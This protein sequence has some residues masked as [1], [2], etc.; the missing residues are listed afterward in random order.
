MKKSG[1]IL[2][3]A[4]SA[5]IVFAYFST[6]E[7]KDDVVEWKCQLAYPIGTSSSNHAT[8]WADTL[9][10][11]T[12]GRIK[13][14]LLPPGAMCSV[15]D[16]VTYLERGV[17]ES[18]VTFGGFYTGLIPETDLE[19]GL[20]LSF[21]DWTEA[22]DCFYNRGLWEVVQNGY[23]KHGIIWFP[24][25][26]EKTYHF[27][28]KFPINNI[29]EDMKGKKIRA[30]GIY[31]KYTA[32]LGASTVTIPGGELYMALKLGTIDGALYGASGLGESKL[33]EVVNYYVYPPACQITESLL[34]S[35]NA[36]SKLPEDLRSIVRYSARS[37]MGEAG[38]QF[39]VDSVKTYR[40]CIAEGK[41]KQIT[42]S[43]DDLNKMRAKVVPLWDELAEKSPNMKKGVE[44]VK[45]HMRDLH[46]SLE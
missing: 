8:F 1:T 33:S 42:L 34:I 21:Q 38:R 37:I 6:S 27:M 46:R 4:L 13:I 14:T 23:D 39:E 16:I 31:G 17:F 43:E 20:P 26:A 3:L 30:V 41:I 18:S 10:K 15:K 24:G 29:M 5:V 22:W 7:A 45:Q 11:M 25:A 35:K 9:S 2:A 28:T 44:I 40:Q 19:M 32:A 36:L 12:N